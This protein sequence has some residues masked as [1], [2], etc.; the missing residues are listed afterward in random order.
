MRTSP[1]GVAMI[2]HY[3]SCRLRP[4]RCPA[5]LWTVGWGHVLQ[6]DML[7]VTYAQRLE[8]PLSPEHDRLW[9]QDEVDAL[10]DAD[11]RP[12]ER[13]VSRL[14]PA[15]LDR[16]GA[17]DALVSFTFN[18][19]AGALQRSTLRQCILQG[20]D[21]AAASEFGR[22]VWSAGRKLKGLVLRRADEAAM[23]LSTSAT[24]P[25]AA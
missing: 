21:V 1:A 6:R 14:C 18:L 16:Q 4:Y 24:L 23:F 7:A 3:E 15:V 11:I 5:G 2:K 10:L 12:A 8:Q 19:G 20:D 25:G 17:F 22:Y 9:T 13:A